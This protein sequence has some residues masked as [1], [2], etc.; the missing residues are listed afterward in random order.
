MF[1]LPMQIPFKST[2]KESACSLLLRSRGAQPESQQIYF[3]HCLSS[4]SVSHSFS[5]SIS[6]P[7]VS[8]FSTV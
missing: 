1:F 3:E 6:H 7:C 4:I 5:P 8:H 2:L